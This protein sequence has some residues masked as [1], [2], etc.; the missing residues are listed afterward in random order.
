MASI[1]DEYQD[2]RPSNLNKNAIADLAHQLANYTKYTVGGD[3]DDVVSNLGGK[4]RYLDLYG[5]G[6]SSDSGSIEINDFM[7]FTITLANHTGPLR[8]RF[9]VAHELGHYVLHYLYPK[10]VLNENLSK[11]KAER[12]GSG[13]VETEA[14]YF[15][16]CLLMPEEE[17]RAEYTSQFGAHSILSD[18]FAV[19]TRASRLRAKN[20]SLE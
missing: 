12:Y 16:A 10:Q 15:A 13:R 18:K 7:D 8:D 14:N 6:N 9:T 17:Y 1:R 5:I 2:A 4:I 11:V 20:L 19:S 3:L